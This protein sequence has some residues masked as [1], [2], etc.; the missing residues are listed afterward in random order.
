MRKLNN[1]LIKHIK[2]NLQ[3]I[4]WIYITLFSA[5]S[6]QVTIA[7]WLNHIASDDTLSRAQWSIYAEYVDNGETIIDY[8]SRNCLAPASSLKIVTTGLT[9][10]KLGPDFK[11]STRLYYS[12]SI[13]RKGTLNGNIYIVG[14]GDPTLGSDQVPGSIPADSLVQ[15]WV[16]AIKGVGIKRIK[17]AIKADVSIFEEQSVPNY[18]PWIDI[19][20]Y[21]GAGASALCFNDNLYH[22][23]FKPG[24]KVGDIAEV[25]GVVPA[26]TGL[27]FD[28]YMKTGPVG[29][30]DNGWIYCAPKL[31]RATLRGTI[32]AGV[33]EFTIKGSLPD[34]ALFT[35]QY[36]S[37]A[38]TVAGVDVGGRPE[39]KHTSSVYDLNKLIYEHNSVELT[40]IARI[41]NQVSVNLYTEQL[42]K[43]MAWYETGEGSMDQ[44][45]EMI[46]TFLDTSGIDIIGW[47]LDDASGLSRTNRVSAR[48]LSKFLS[49]M[50]STPVF[51]EYYKSFSIAANPED[52]GSVSRIGKGTTL[53]LNGRIKTGTI[54]GVRSHTGYLTTGSGRLVSFSLICNNYPVSMR[55]INNIH[56]SILIQLALLP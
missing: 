21:Y 31:Y 3:A 56:E 36:L 11:F 15:T 37:T 53:A 33:D 22:L 48:Q 20:N 42:V 18:W 51:D 7:E 27:E 41:T 6:A 10:V 1:T 43:Y 45:L 34:P 13:N 46:E 29:S 16:A 23:T 47:K 44:G 17:G 30:G 5:L 55:R 54:H 25:I 28:N 9:L 19:G 49:V 40:D 39:V 38:L 12:G 8:N 2:N 52:S 14:G 4:V 35:A 32:P 50:S 24:E 26:M